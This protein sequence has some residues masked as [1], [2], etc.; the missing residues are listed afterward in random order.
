MEKLIVGARG[1]GLSLAQTNYLVG[2]LKK[3]V[4]ADFEVRIIKTAGDLDRASPLASGW[5]QGIFTRAIETELLEGRID[6]AVHSLKDLPLNQPEGLAVA[7][8][9]ARA[10]PRDALVAAE[11]ILLDSDESLPLTKGASV[12]TSSPRRSALIKLA[13]PDLTILP[14]R[15]NLPTRLERI[16]KGELDGAVMA[17]AGIERLKPDLDGLRVVPLEPGLFV[18]APGQGA[19]AVE[20]RLDHPRFEAVRNAA[21]DLAAEACVLLERRMLEMFG[22]GCSLPIGVLADK[23]GDDFILNG[24]RAGAHGSYWAQV[25][26]PHPDEVLKMLYERL[27]DPL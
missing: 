13:R 5:E 18:P 1:S 21:N 12:G 19:L 24:F 25:Y 11:K 22:G 15:G 2:L 9:P 23:S 20:L 8:V 14:L 26:S 6:L 10:D 3:S 7:A 16:R 27:R 4:D 17:M